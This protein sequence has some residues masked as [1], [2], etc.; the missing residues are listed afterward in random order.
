MRFF[1][2]EL[3]YWFR[4]PMV[5]VFFFINL[6]LIFGATSSDQ[7]RVGGSFGNILKNAPYVIQ[8]YYSV[9][10]FIS[11]LMTTS[12]ILASTTRDFTYNTYQ[13]IFTT[14]VKRIQYLLGRFFGAV[15]VSV[16]PLLGVS[17]GIILGCLMPWVDSEKVGAFFIEAHLAGIFQIAVPNTLFG[18][19]VVFMV[20]S[21]TRNTIAAF[22]SSLVLMVAMVV[23]GSFSED[24]E[25]E[26]LAILLD[27]YGA[28][29]FSILTKYWTVGQKNTIT[30]A[31]EGLFLYNR[32]LWTLISVIIIT[33]TVKVFSFTEKAK[34]LKKSLA[35][36][37]SQDSFRKLKSVPD[38]KIS[39]GF[40]AQWIM[41]KKRLFFELFAI[42]KSP[43][44]IVILIAGLLN[45][46]PNIITNSGPFGLTA[47][48]V[49]YSMINMIEGSFYMFLIS[50]IIIYSGQLVWKERE[51]QFDEIYDAT[52]HKKWVT[53]LSKISAM[54]V[55]IFLIQS[56]LIV[57]CVVTQLAKGFDDIRLMVYIKSLLLI[58]YTGLMFLVIMA[59]LMH[60]LINNKYLAFFA[61]VVFLLLNNFL[62]VMLEVETNMVQ[63]GS[64]PSYI[65]SDMN[66]FGPFLQG[67][68]WF[69]G[70]WLL[71]AFL[72]CFVS[73]FA[74]IRG[75]ETSL[76][77]K[78]KLIFNGIRGR[79]RPILGLILMLWLFFGSFVYYNIYEL[80]SIT[81]SYQLKEFQADYEKTYKKYEGINQ[82]RIT[83]IKY[84]ISIFPETRAVKVKGV[85]WIKNKGNT[86]IDSVHV[87]FQRNFKIILDF[88]RSKNVLHDTKLLYN[89]YKLHE[90]LSP[91]DSI[92]VSF[93]SDFISKGFENEVS[94]TSVVGNGSFFNNLDFSPEIGYQPGRELDDKDERKKRGL[95]EKA[96]MPELKRNCGA[97]CMNNYLTNNSDWL[98]VETVI[99]TS[100]DQTA[101]APG[102]AIKTWQKDNRNYFHYKLDHASLNFYSFISAK[103]EIEKEKYNGIDV[104]V[105]YDKAHHYNIENMQRSMKRS[106]DYYIQ[107]FGPYYHKQ[108]R[109]IEFPR[110]AGFAQA[111]PGTM[112]YSEGIGFI[113]KI[114]DEDDID[115]VFYVVAHEMAH[116]YWAHQIIGAGVQG[117]TL[118]SETFAQYSAL[119]VMEKEYGRDAMKKF[120]KY[121]M[122]NYLRQRGTE[123]VKEE[124]L[125]KVENQGYIHY[126]KGSLVMYYLKEMIGETALNNA[127]RELLDQFKYA[128]PPYPTSFHALDAI[129]AHT[130]DSLQYVITDLFETITLFNNRAVSANVKELN[131]GKFELTLKVATQKFRADS[132]GFE[133]EIPV[134]DWIEI[135]VFAKPEQETSSGK[136]LYRKKHYISGKENTIT[137]VLNE[138]PFE[139]G[140]DPMNLMVDLIGDDNLIKVE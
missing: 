95:A 125:L 115:M 118:L 32:I 27:P 53:Y 102:S 65:Y 69:R 56:F 48:P 110:Y 126:R 77:H 17:A 113:A 124:P 116:Q 108:V 3:K 70:Y 104:E 117:A 51:S 137:L 40:G 41:Y 84:N 24:L 107:N 134:K 82:P 31:L 133:T 140:I 1:V 91:G 39:L 90:P 54:A 23:A 138:K 5:Y 100:S 34:K 12:F 97:E 26:W 68:F 49:T 35:V 81:T 76:T 20:A 36:E 123:S 93:T 30:L 105:Y 43:A 78:L 127:L 92:K 136:V 15:I 47:Y 80:N 37:E 73:V 88:P 22:I 61:F 21:L 121:E 62:W 38:A 106:L 130:P 50:I 112:P 63:Y 58:D 4:Q 14:P 94:F 96:R 79:S 98:N 28:Q 10:S 135:G 85:W 19:A 57:I 120:L 6:L 13:I 64:R 9:M 139:A 67:I 131:S 46:V 109:I 103:Y 99:S 83:D 111:F 132:L 44:F 45:F 2:F 87:N 66:G 122:D 16:V 86:T 74:W 33:T 72:I 8:T 55:L 25:T 71:F 52:P 42:L 7:I 11:L 18:A 114:E 119:M 59:M 128:E 129:K 89:I 60:S 101:I 29:T 75:K